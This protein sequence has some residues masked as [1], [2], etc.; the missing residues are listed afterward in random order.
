M[1]NQRYSA[2]F[3]DEAVRQVLDRGYSVKEVSERLGVS[4]HSLYK[5]VNTVRPAPEKQHDEE[6]LEAKREILI[7]RAKLRRVEEERDILKRPPGTLRESP[8]EARIRR[9]ASTAV[10]HCVISGPTAFRSRCSKDSYSAPSGSNHARFRVARHPAAP[11]REWPA[12]SSVEAGPVR[13]PRAVS[14]AG[15]FAV[16]ETRIRSTRPAPAGS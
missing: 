6:L 4:S 15:Y 10:S 12:C 7:L 3:R 8:S 11:T 14:P 1:S 2:E 9:V 13:R 16:T 5:W